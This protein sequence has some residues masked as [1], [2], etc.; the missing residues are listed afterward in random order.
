MMTSTSWITALPGGVALVETDLDGDG[1]VD[2]QTQT[3]W[4]ALGVER[5]LY[6]W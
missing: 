3:S 6:G 1:V 5:Y 2:T 4:F